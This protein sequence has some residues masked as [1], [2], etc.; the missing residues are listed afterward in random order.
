MHLPESRTAQRLPE[1]LGFRA[2]S[3]GALTS[4]TTMSA[5]LNQL[6][7]ALPDAVHR[8]DYRSALVEQNVLSKPTRSSR[9][10]TADRLRT[11]YSLDPDVTVFRTLRYFWS[12]S[13]AE[14]R[15][16]L[17][18]LAAATR[19]P[20]LRVTAEPVLSARQGAVV[21]TGDL[22]AAVAS[23]F[24]GR[25]AP[26]TLNIIAR[27]VAS[28]WAQSGHLAGHRVKKRSR[29]VP[30]PASAAYALL[31]GYLCGL[32]GQLLLTT[33]WT[34]MLDISPADL[35]DLASRA[36]RLGWIDYRK[37]GST[38]EVRFPRLLRAD[39]EEATVGED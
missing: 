9:R 25:F 8:D 30:S 23:A 6:L 24:P 1:R 36:S 32:R 15:P 14:E 33:P 20:L 3:S 37:V 5:E 38:V 29:P 27:N 21:T 12:A 10:I 18:L 7:A 39:E 19:E 16:L 31:L 13:G 34:A 17:I 2:S 22:A 4:R 11:I 26:S 28:S 35:S